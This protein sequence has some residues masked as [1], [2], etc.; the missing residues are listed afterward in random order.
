MNGTID[1][2]QGEFT[3]STS[4]TDVGQLVDFVQDGFFQIV[5]N[6]FAA[7]L[8]LETKLTLA[9]ERTFEKQ[10]TEFGLP[11]FSVNHLTSH[12]NLIPLY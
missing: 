3:V 5:A 9:K 4:D 8:E 1:I 12:K 10:L 6:N 2:I 7:H 11:G